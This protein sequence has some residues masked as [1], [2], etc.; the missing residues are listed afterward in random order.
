MRKYKRHAGNYL[1]RNE[2]LEDISPLAL[3]RTA[4]NRLAVCIG[5]EFHLNDCPQSATLAQ[6]YDQYR[7]R[8]VKVEL[9]W[10]Y[11]AQTAPN[12]SVGGFAGSTAMQPEVYWYIDKDDSRAPGV[13]W[14]QS[15][16]QTGSARHSRLSD[17]R[18][19]KMILKPCP[20]GQ[21]YRSDLTTG[22]T[23]MARAPWID[24]KNPD[25]PHYGLKYM[26]TVPVQLLGDDMV[27]TEL[28]HGLI[29]TRTTYAI[30]YK[31]YLGT[32][33]A[34][35]L[36]AGW[37]GVTLDGDEAIDTIIEKEG[38]GVAPEQHAMHDPQAAV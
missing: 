18:A 32:A 5:K 1:R 14:F 26:I 38:E 31:N 36:A 21:I 29:Q 13:Q 17:T 28:K 35:S 9:R 19:T 4:G 27:A 2:I 25:V 8:Y 11:Q 15:R 24:C 6:S 22:Y 34:F 12:P 3:Y 20:S 7:I 37:E 23:V 10:W 33:Q 30:E 16:I